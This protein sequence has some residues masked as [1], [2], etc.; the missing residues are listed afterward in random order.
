MLRREKHGRP[1]AGE[2]KAWLRSLVSMT[3]AGQAKVNARFAE[4]RLRCGEEMD[5]FF[6][7]HSDQRP[8]QQ[9]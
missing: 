7:R 2:W 6:A 9:T 5:D 1:R 3:W 4:L 8:P